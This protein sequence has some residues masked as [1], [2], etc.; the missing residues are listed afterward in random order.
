MTWSI[1]QKSEENFKRE[2]KRVGVS[3]RMWEEKVDDKLT[4]KVRKLSRPT[5]KPFILKID[6]KNI[7]L[8]YVIFRRYLPIHF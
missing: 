7:H 2:L 6:T 8:L 4:T 5:G 1:D 3:F